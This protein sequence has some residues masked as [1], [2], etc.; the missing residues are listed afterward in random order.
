MATLE[1]V[2]N[3]AFRL[4]TLDKVRLI[5]KVSPRI[6]QELTAG[7]TKP[8]Q[9]LWGSCRDLG[10]APSAEEIDEARREQWSGFP[11]DDI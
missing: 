11:R 4:S 7:Q 3:Q 8:F 2:L 9:S 6:E 1:A 10:A 5:E